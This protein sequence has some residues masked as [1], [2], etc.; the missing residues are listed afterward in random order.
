MKLLMFLG[1]IAL[2]LLA[3]LL[4]YWWGRVLLPEVGL[5]AP[6]YWTWFWSL[7]PVI[8]SYGVGYF[9]KEALE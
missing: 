1:A 2:W 6:E 7:L 9:V 5:S 3:A 4:S 8:I